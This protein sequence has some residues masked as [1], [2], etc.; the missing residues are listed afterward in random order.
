[1]AQLRAAESA[2]R[3]LAEIGNFIARGK[4]YQRRPVC[5]YIKLIRR[6]GE[7]EFTTDDLKM[8]SHL[9]IRHSGWK[10]VRIIILVCSI[11]ML[12]MSIYG[13]SAYPSAPEGFIFVNLIAL[14]A[15]GLSYCVGGWAGRPEVS[16]L[17]KLIEERQK[18]TTAGQ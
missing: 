7:M 15:L 14:G 17:L 1:V 13:L 18:E 12:A 3:D 4:P 10:R 8:I 9:K 6:G 2:E 11:G 16:L 5:H